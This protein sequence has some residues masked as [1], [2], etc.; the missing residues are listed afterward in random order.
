LPRGEAGDSA[1]VG[2]KIVAR[3]PSGMGRA[4]KNISE[5]AFSLR[6]SGAKI[7]VSVEMLAYVGTQGA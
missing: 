1:Q 2:V 5:R 7:G 4:P 6:C 3:H